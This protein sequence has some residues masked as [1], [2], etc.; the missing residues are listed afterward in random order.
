LAQKD[1]SA[2]AGGRDGQNLR[3]MIGQSSPY[4]MRASNFG[5]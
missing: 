3:R 2:G 4:A 5:A 1:R